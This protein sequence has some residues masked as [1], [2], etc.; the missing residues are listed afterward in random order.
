MSTLRWGIIGCGDVCE[1][2]SGP[3]F[4]KVPDSSLIAVMR[5]DG[6]KAQDFARRHQVPFHYAEAIELLNHPDVNA[7]YIATP[8][9]SHEH[10]LELA[11]A[12]A[13]PVYVEKPVSLDKAGCERMIKLKAKYSGMVSVA[14]YRRELPL[15]KKIKSLIN[16]GAI[17]QI[18]FIDIQ[19]QHEAP[20]KLDGLWR[21]DPNI[22]GG[23]IF[24]D[25]SPHQLDILYWI[26]GKPVHVEGF[27]VNQTKLYDAPDNVTL[28]ALF[29]NDIPFTGRWAFNAPAHAVKEECVIQGED[30]T[31]KFSFFKNPVLEFVTAHGMQTFRFDYPENIQL[32][33][34]DAVTKYFLGDGANPCSLEDALEV[35]KMID[36]AKN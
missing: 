29:E 35:M 2:K 23:G 36:A 20:K 13:K 24:H 19:L 31:L 14:H 28:H 26:F 3:A 18:R 21:V 17:G 6:A 25:L 34:I 12:T 30:G 10:Y 5:R 33:M 16:G 15:F 8:P 27:S 4:K 32:P 9:D 22:S 11:L 7:I 1:I